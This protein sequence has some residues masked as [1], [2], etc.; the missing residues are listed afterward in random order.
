MSGLLSNLSVK[1]DQT[2]FQP[3]LYQVASA[4]LNPSDIAAPIRSLLAS[5]AN[6]TTRQ[7][8]VQSIDLKNRRLVLEQ[9]AL[10]YDF[11]VLAA[12]VRHSYFGNPQW[13]AFAPG[14]KT[15]DDALEIRKRVLTAFEAAELESD[16]EK[17]QSWLTLV[18]V[19]GGPTGVELAGAMCELAR[20]TL[21]KDFRRFDPS[22]T[23]VILVEAGPRLLTAFDP[24][25]AEKGLRALLKLGVEVRL[26]TPVTAVDE[27]GVMLGGTFVAAR[28]VLWAAGVAAA[29]LVSTLGVE[30]DKIGRVKVGAD[31][32]IPGYPEAFV[33]GD[34]ACFTAADGTVLPGLAPVAMQQGQHAASAIVDTLSGRP[35]QPFVYFDKG[36]MATVGRAQ[37]LAQSGRLRLSGFIGWLAWLFIHLL[38]LVDFRSRLLV[39]LQWSW[40]WFTYGRSARLITGTTPVPEAPSTRP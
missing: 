23:R 15:L 30:L 18:V 36:I 6:V 9:G 8:L 17:Q 1:S 10:E 13:E 27:R 34:V 24:R 19:G 5:H 38:F 12:G 32:S 26:N 4:G 14:L 37:G 33:V 21:A 29:P 16:S 28:T 39:S 3:L 2:H 22:K 7:A 31:L 25:L 40:A 20:F 35:R 11:L